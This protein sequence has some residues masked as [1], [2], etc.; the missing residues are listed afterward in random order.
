MERGRFPDRDGKPPVSL[1]AGGR[2]VSDAPFRAK[3]GRRVL[4]FEVPRP[5]QLSLP[6]DL[7]V[8]V[9]DEDDAHWAA[10]WFTIISVRLPDDGHRLSRRRIIDTTEGR[11][12]GRQPVF[13]FSPD[14]NAFTG[15]YR[16]E[17]VDGETQDELIAFAEG[18][19]RLVGSRPNQILAARISNLAWAESSTER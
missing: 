6:P 18:V 13:W 11:L 15:T 1:E 8:D 5:E 16:V 2:R 4:S 7:S 14:I 17:S 19:T 9:D 12:K 10:G 3:I